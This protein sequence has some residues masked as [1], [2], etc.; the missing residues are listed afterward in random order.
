MK[1]RLITVLTVLLAILLGGKA[2]L[3]QK[4]VLLMCLMGIGFL[5][6]EKDKNDEVSILHRA[7]FMVAFDLFWIIVMLFPWR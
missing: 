3:S 4:Y 1:Y 2:G 6:L 5:M 7:G